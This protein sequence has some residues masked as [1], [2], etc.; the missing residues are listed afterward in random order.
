MQSAF[1]EAFGRTPVAIGRAP[2]RVNLIGDHT[3]YAEG[4]C[5]PMPLVHVIEVAVAPAQSF[6]AMSLTNGEMQ[7][8]DPSGLPRGNWTDY[9]AGSLAELSKL[10]IEV[11]PV[12]VLV[13]SDV[14]QGAGVSSSAALEV[15]TI[16]AALELAGVTLDDVA[17]AQAAQRA[18]NL[19][20][21]MQCGIL[22]QMASAV[23]RQGEALL[24]DCRT[25]RGE[26]IHVPSVFRFAVVHCG[27]ERRLVE[28]AYNERRRSV[29]AA[30][31]LLGVRALR[32]ASAAMA[33]SL[34]DPLLRMRARHVVGENE[35][36]L[37]AVGAMKNSQAERFGTL[38]VESHRSLAQD[39]EVSTEALDRLV[40][41]ALEAGAYG[42]R[43]TGA[44]F[45]GCIV[46]LLPACD[47]SK[48]WSRV[49]ARNPS[50]W[51]VQI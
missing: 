34:V 19:Y 31:G 30:A 12:D 13:R 15:A 20:C 29:E 32:D 17:V 38:M 44:G 5:L 49:A 18:E 14:P 10:G 50:A 9:I 25:N 4:F 26:L 11:P 40:D 35:R 1:V 8:F 22:D 51:C 7:S 43:L 24:L 21:G 28:G 37:A 23:G 27:Q 36:V 42:A 39:F 48:W 6:Q 41:S 16:R 33:E 45:G 46:A 2:G 3:D 47:T